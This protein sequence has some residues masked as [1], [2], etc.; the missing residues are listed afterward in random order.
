MPLAD[1]FSHSRVKVNNESEKKIVFYAYYI[2]DAI[3][4]L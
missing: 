2:N 3:F 1:T 4:N